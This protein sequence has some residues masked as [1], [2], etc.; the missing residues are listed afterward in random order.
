LTSEQMGSKMIDMF[1]YLFNAKKEGRPR[2]TVTKV[3]TRKYEKTG[4]VTR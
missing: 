2:Y 4:I 3:E 1:D